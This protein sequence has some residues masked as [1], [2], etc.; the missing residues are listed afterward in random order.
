MK[1]TKGDLVVSFIAYFVSFMLA[2]G[3]GAVLIYFILHVNPF[4]ALSIIVTSA[5]FMSVGQRTTFYILVELT[6]IS[7]GLALSY[8]AR[9]WNI[10]ADGQYIFG[11]I[12]GMQ[13]VF[14]LEHIH[15]HSP[16]L[17]VPAIL[18]MGLLGGMLYGLIPAL[19]KVVLNVNEVL[20][21]LML[22]FI[23]IYF[24]TW[25]VDVTGPWKDPYAAEL[26][27]Y[28]IPYSY[29]LENP[30]VLIAIMAAAIIIIYLLAGKTSFGFKIKIMGSSLNAA[31]Y[32]G[33]RKATV[34]VYLGI[35][36]GGLSGIA[37]AIDLLAVSHILSSTFDSLYMGYL[38]IF[39]TWLASLN[40]LFVV[41]SSLL[42]STLVSGGYFM[43]ALSGV[44]MLF[45]YYFEGIVFIS[46][47]IFET[48]K[49]RLKRMMGLE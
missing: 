40:P 10:G 22:N 27:S 12:L 3:L 9:F 35:I 39:T 23:A 25:L 44:S 49:G 4:Y 15:V 2:I 28:P 47:I 14:A 29:Y 16:F 30:F 33:V 21:S 17:A 13:T 36:S 42:M 43:E 11:A 8:R 1:V 24:M 26:E 7:L 5:L 6:L 41:L 32:A 18:L 38:S 19:L 37:G 31:E 46:I 45:V 34:Y 48:M 20:S